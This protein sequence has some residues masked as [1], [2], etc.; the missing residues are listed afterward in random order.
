[1]TKFKGWTVKSTEKV[2]GSKI[3]KSKTSKKKNDHREN[4]IHAALNQANIKHE[5]GY[6][7][8][9]TRKWKFDFALPEYKIAVEYEGGTYSGGGHTR[10]AHYWSDCIKYREAALLGWV[11]LRY[12]CNDLDKKVQKTKKGKVTFAGTGV[13]GI[14]KDIL[15]LI[16]LL[17]QN[18]IK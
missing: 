18:P 10:G 13:E 15:Q 16:N 14:A 5:R 17:Q 2:T 11:V 3:A 9:P 4:A 1:M 12:V 8:H 6:I 7:F